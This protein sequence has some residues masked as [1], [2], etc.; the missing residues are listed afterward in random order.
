MAGPDFPVLQWRLARAAHVHA[1]KGR[2]EVKFWLSDCSV[3]AAR[4]VPQHELT[5]LQQKVRQH[6]D[7]FLEKWH[8][9]FG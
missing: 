5:T 4:R 1:R 3:A 2:Q 6:R 8:A 9:H 7:E